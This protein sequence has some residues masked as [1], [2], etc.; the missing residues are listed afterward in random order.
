MAPTDAARGGRCAADAAGRR[1]RRFSSSCDA[2]RQRKL[3][4]AARRGDRGARARVVDCHLPLVRAL[5]ARYRDFGLP[6]D[7]LVQEGVIGLLDAIDHYDPSR[8]PAFE[9]YARFRVRRAIRNALTEQAR[10]FRLPKQDRRA[11]P[12]S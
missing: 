10:L 2:V 11:P 4:R 12:H 9:P 8:G 5:A 1:S 6:L 7:D 3:L